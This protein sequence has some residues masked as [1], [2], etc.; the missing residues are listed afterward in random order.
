MRHAPT[1][2]KWD[3]EALERLNAEPWMVELLDLNPGYCSW[4]PHEDYMMRHGDES[5]HRQDLSS[6]GL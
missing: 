5:F 6:N 4:G 1:D 2:D 3:R